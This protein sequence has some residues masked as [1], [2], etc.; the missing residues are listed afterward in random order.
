M[1]RL[2]GQHIAADAGRRLAMD[3][4]GGGP[5]PPRKIKWPDLKKCEIITF[6]IDKKEG[7]KLGVW[8]DAMDNEMEQK[9]PV[10][11]SKCAD[12][13]HAKKHGVRPYDIIYKINGHEI[14]VPK[15]SHELFRRAKPGPVEIVIVRPPPG[16]VFFSIRNAIGVAAGSVAAYHTPVEVNLDGTTDLRESFTQRGL[17]FAAAFGVVALL[18]WLVHFV[19]ERQ[20]EAAEAAERAKLPPPPPIPHVELGCSPPGGVYHAASRAL[21]LFGGHLPLPPPARLRPR[22]TLEVIDDD[23]DN[24]GTEKGGSGSETALRVTPTRD[25]F[26]VTLVTGG[27]PAERPCLRCTV[28]PLNVASGADAVID[29]A[30]QAKLDAT[31][32]RG[33]DAW[34]AAVSAAPAFAACREANWRGVAALSPLAPEPTP[35][36]LANGRSVLLAGLAKKPELNGRL[37][38]IASAATPAATPAATGDARAS[39]GRYP[40]RLAGRKEPLL[41]QPANLRPMR[42]GAAEGG[43]PLLG[44]SAAGLRA[45]ASA[46]SEQLRGLTVSQAILE[47]ILPLTAGAGASLAAALH[48]AAN[49]ADAGEEGPLVGPATVAILTPDC[50]QLSDVLEAAEGLAAREAAAREAAAVAATAA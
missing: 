3:P 12:G 37:G 14:T 5:P 39:A 46:H 43:A 24:D 19:R 25:G 2:P 1:T 28:A 11:V 44:L 10:V 7:D 26:E 13:Y 48:A 16:F 27:T 23:D 30:T 49:P 42:P 36:E 35:D 4:F 47:L 9:R 21:E 18:W 29:A 17:A 8:L 50:A 34:M 41:L 20:R 22:Q 38:T 40:V 6:T 31:W 32:Q 45:F 15:L 33:R